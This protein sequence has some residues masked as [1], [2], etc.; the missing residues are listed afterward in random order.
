MYGEPLCS[1]SLSRRPCARELQSGY[2]IARIKDSQHSPLLDGRGREKNP[3]VMYIASTCALFHSLQVSVTSGM[4]V[5]VRLELLLLLLLQK[6]GRR[7]VIGTLRNQ[8]FTPLFLSPAG[9]RVAISIPAAAAVQLL[10]LESRHST[11]KIEESQLY[12]P[13]REDCSRP[14]SSSSDQLIVYNSVLSLN[15]V[16]FSELT[17]RSIKMCSQ[18]VKCTPGRNCVADYCLSC[19]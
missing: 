7:K 2:S 8:L 16:I 11:L 3:S 1:F 9:I 18:P 19:Y 12:Y 14:T 4:D 5:V 6:G 17:P 10:E 13:T 15:R